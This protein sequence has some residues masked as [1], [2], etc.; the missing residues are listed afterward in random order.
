MYQRKVH[1]AH[2]LM[3]FHSYSLEEGEDELE[4][5]L[6]IICTLSIQSLCKSYCVHRR[7]KKS[8][9]VFGIIWQ[10][11]LIHQF[12]PNSIVVNWKE[13]SS[14]WTSRKSRAKKFVGIGIKYKFVN[15]KHRKLKSTI[16]IDFVLVLFVRMSCLLLIQL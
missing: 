4:R 13:I 12:C 3:K 15:E 2:L 1:F 8:T 9:T 14:F 5:A 10:N 11:A 16:D 7:K 6:G